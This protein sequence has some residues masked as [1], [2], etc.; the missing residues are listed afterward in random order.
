M[1]RPNPLIFSPCPI[2]GEI[3]ITL[4]PLHEP[5]WIQLTSTFPVSYFW[6]GALA[7]SQALSSNQSLNQINQLVE[8]LLLIFNNRVVANWREEVERVL[9][10]TPS[11]PAEDEIFGFLVNIFK[12]KIPWNTLTGWDYLQSPSLLTS[13]SSSYLIF[14]TQ[15]KNWIHPP[16]RTM[17]ALFPNNGRRGQTTLALLDRWQENEKAG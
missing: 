14:L 1:I 15:L 16:S 8:Q 11:N 3:F 12:F 4:F 7:R 9:I 5:N 2:P 13:F 17:R 6:T 10:L